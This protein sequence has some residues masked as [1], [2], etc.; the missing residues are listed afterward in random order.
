MS[1][2]SHITQYAATSLWSVFAFIASTALVAAAQPPGRFEAVREKARKLISEG[3]IPALSIGVAQDGKIIWEEGFGFSDQNGKVRA[4]PHTRY[5]IGSTTKPITATAIMLL[6]EQGKIDLDRPVSQYLPQ[7]LAIGSNFGDADRIT[8][9]RLMNHT[10]GLP[11]HSQ[12]FIGPEIGES[13]RLDRNLGRYAFTVKPAGEAFEY[14]NLGYALLSRVV[15]NVSGRGFGEFLYREIFLPLGMRNTSLDDGRK[16][17]AVGYSPDGA[18][19]DRVLSDSPGS[20]DVLTDVHD[21]LLFGMSNLGFG[22]KATVS[23]EGLDAM[24]RPGID[25]GISQYGLGF[26][27]VKIG[28]Y[29]RLF[30]DGSNGY[31]ISVFVLI[32]ERNVCI[33]I[34]TNKVSNDVA[35]LVHDIVSDLIPDYRTELDRFRAQPAPAETTAFRITE[36]Y[37]GHWKGQIVTWKETL[38]V[39]MW[40]QADG[41]IH[42]QMQGQYRNLLNGVRIENGYLRGSFQ[43]DI[44]TDDARRHPYNLHLKLKL[45]DGG[46]L[47]GSLTSVS[48][49]PQGNVL[50]SWIELRKQ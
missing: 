25:R 39:D 41:D 22:R 40:F 45:R 31:G 30:H 29:T 36:A 20:S 7:G 28:K 4:G 46:I 32:P 15:A 13:G 16:I 3:R 12:Y 21:L 17:V 19:A 50:S 23:R 47:N 24:H 44:R 42:V 43:G 1:I 34:L 49:S 6:A 26:E 9:R 18:V 27:S 14:S 35:P 38:P 2:R 33:T 10:S 8:V 48:T 37:S 5:N 11:R